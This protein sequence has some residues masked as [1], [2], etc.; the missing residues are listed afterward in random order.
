[1]RAELREIEVGSGGVAAGHRF[2]ETA[3]GVVAVE[4]DAVDEDCEDFDDDFDDAADQ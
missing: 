4:G 2:P 3:L 1:L